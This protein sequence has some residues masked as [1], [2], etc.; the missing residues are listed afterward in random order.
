M[1]EGV[2]IL[3]DTFEIK[4]WNKTAFKILKSQEDLYT[5]KNKDELSI[6]DLSTVIFRPIKLVQETL[7][8]DLTT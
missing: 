6:D 7:Q 5:Y 1:H 3:S 4:F 2:L 8:P